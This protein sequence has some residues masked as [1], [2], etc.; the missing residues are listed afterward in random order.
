LELAEGF[1]NPFSSRSFSHESLPGSLPVVRFP[2]R[3]DQLLGGRP[4]IPCSGPTPNISSVM[5]L[6]RLQ[7]YTIFVLARN[8]LTKPSCGYVNSLL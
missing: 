3:L 2:L 4:A 5:P 8:N 7:T 1:G 6:I